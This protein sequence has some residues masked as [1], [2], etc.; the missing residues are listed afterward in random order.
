MSSLGQPNPIAE[1][2]D[3]SRTIIVIAVAAVIAIML[4]LAFLLRESPK[5]VKPVSPYWPVSSFRI[6]R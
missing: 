1:E 3:S 2:R 5:A 6:S 4:G